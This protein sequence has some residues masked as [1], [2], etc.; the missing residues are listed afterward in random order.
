MAVHSDAW[1]FGFSQE[2]T[3]LRSFSG[4]DAG[5]PEWRNLGHILIEREMLLQFHSG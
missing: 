2:I 1:A 4:T 3:T 5:V